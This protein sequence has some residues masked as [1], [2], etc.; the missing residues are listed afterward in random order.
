MH[1]VGR[2]QPLKKRP[3]IRVYRRLIKLANRLTGHLGLAHID[4]GSIKLV[5]DVSRIELLDH[6]NRCA[7]ILGNLVDV[8][9]L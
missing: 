3:R 6:F 8:R 1:H 2:F 5:L 9:P 4:G 7:A